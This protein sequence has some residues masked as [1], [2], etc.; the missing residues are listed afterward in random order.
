MY[1][2]H[3]FYFPFKWEISELSSELFSNQVSLDHIKLTSSSDWIAG[4]SIA[5]KQEADDLYNEKNY[6]YEFVHSVLYDE[7]KADAII[8]H[9]ERK[10]PKSSR[11]YY[12]IKKK[13]GK[14][15]VLRVESINLNFYSTG[16]GTLSFYL[17]NDSEIQKSLQDILNI[18]QYGRRIF[19]PFIADI[20]PVKGYSEIAEYISIEGLRKGETYYWEDFKGYTPADVWKSA[21]FIKQLIDDLGIVLKINPIIDD[22]MFVV[23]WYG[24]N[25]LSQKIAEES[26]QDKFIECDDWYKYVF[27]DQN[28]PSCQNTEMKKELLNQTTYKRW[29]RY[30]TLYGVSRYSLVAISDESQFSKECL[31]VYMRT[32]YSRMIELILVQR[33][34]M[35]RFSGEVSRLSRLSTVD[36]ELLAKQI[37]SLYKE[38]IRFVN[39]IYFRE[40]TAQEQGI[41]LYDMLHSNLKIDD[42]IKDLD[43]EIEELHQYVSLIV[44]RHRSN[45]AAT[46]NK[47]AAIFLPV[48]IIT[49]IWGMN[50]L[51]D[52]FGDVLVFIPF[53][54]IFCGIG[55]TY[56]YFIYKKR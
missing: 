29:Q 20:D 52:V 26:S 5:N 41:E 34:S 44:E 32:I 18:N 3:I 55:A 33:G 1:S 21:R 30:G 16:I 11:V 2:Y 22:R 48:T 4:N 7:N 24:N 47:L 6:Y 10:E 17:L 39:Q 49:G 36:S 42:Y 51:S 31:A 14:E 23:C 38:Y 54:L 19:P 50:K 27:I 35:L 13:G 8:K 12:K 56:Y 46:L 28:F 15:Y 9:Y 40:V 53:I 25:E 45:Q 43:G 37:S